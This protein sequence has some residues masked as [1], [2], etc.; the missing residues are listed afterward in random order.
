MPCTQV[1]ALRLCLG[2]WAEQYLISCWLQIIEFLRP[3]YSLVENVL[4]AW[5]KDH[6]TWVFVVEVAR[7]IMHLPRQ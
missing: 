6:A 2:L 7:K 3:A 5:K 1:L 4:D